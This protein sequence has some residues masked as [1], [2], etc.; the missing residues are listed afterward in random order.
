MLMLRVV[1][2]LYLTLMRQY[3]YREGLDVEVLIRKPLLVLRN[4]YYYM[5]LVKL[6]TFEPL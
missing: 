4:S 6:I 5:D 3:K 1:L 2:M